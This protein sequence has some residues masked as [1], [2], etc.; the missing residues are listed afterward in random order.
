MTKTKQ[1]HWG[2]WFALLGILTLML[3]GCGRTTQATAPAKN[4]AITNG[5]HY[6][7]TLFFHGYGSSAHAEMHMIHAAQ[8]AGVTKTVLRATVAKN[9]RVTW[10]GKFKQGDNQ[11][12]VA[13]QFDDNRNGDYA[14]TA[15]WVKAVVLGLQRTYHI[16]QFNVVGHSMGNMA[17]VYYLLAN[18]QN[19]HLPQLQKQVDIAGHFNGILG[20]NDAPNR[21]Q[22]TTAGKPTKMDRDYQQLLVLRHQFPRQIQVLNIYGDLNDGTHSDGRVSNAS[23]K[24]LRY[25]VQPRAKSYQ[26]RR[27]VGPN[28]QHSKLHS[29]PQVDRALIHFLWNQSA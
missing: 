19:R 4:P 14:T 7:P 5:A 22:L 18:G 26:E 11:P 16:T 12:L 10:S 17:I 24:S 15:G 21:M 6:V 27:I 2:R 13:V 1:S 28:A 29:N 3:S 25:L 20:M 8:A 9:G 23:S